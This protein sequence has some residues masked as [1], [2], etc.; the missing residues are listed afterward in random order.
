M[1]GRGIY[2][3]IFLFNLIL[4]SGNRI[5]TSG[6]FHIWQTRNNGLNHNWF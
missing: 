4:K 2:A 1:F 3:N 6:S 5:Q